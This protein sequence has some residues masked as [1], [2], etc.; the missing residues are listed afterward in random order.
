M[1]VIGAMLSLG[2]LAALVIFI[3]RVFAGKGKSDIASA[4]HSVTQ[5]IGIK[6]VEAINTQQV[7][8]KKKIEENEALAVE[9][10]E[11]IKEVK[12]EAT[13][14]ITDILKEDKD[15]IKLVEKE[16]ELWDQ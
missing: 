15:F 5:S 7:E 14:K 9:T 11:K 3:Q 8:V 2:G 12:K 16:N 10:R 6:K 1:N 4:V 13:E